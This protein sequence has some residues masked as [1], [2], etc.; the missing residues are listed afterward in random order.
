MISATLSM[1]YIL[2][3]ERDTR[4]FSSAFEKLLEEK[5]LNQRKADKLTMLMKQ[6]LWLYQE[7]I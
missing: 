1:N 3:M 2:A 5:I 4:E 7:R 6:L